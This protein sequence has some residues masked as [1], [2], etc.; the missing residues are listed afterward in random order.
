[1]LLWMVEATKWGSF[2][3]PVWARISCHSA[4]LSSVMGDS[5]PRL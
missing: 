2:D 3:L 1:M 5:F 4:A